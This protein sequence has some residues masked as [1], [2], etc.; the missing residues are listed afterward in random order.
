M[1]AAAGLTGLW[2]IQQLGGR[3]QQGANTAK[4]VRRQAAAAAASSS[5]DTAAAAQQRQVALATTPTKQGTA[6]AAASPGSPLRRAL[7][8]G[9]GGGTAAALKD[10]GLVCFK[11]RTGQLAVVTPVGSGSAFSLQITCASG[12]CATLP[13]GVGGLPYVGSDSVF[14]ARQVGSSWAFLSVG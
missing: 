7:G 1:F 11:D 9:R 2:V 14:L 12:G 13:H 3:H 6:S 8:F 5:D 4:V 10:G